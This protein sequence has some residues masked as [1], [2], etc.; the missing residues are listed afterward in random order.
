M[1]EQEGA[2]IGCGFF[3][4][5][6]LH[7]WQE[8]EGA[9]IEAVCDLEET[10][11]AQ[12]A[13]AFDI[14]HVY[15]DMNRMMAERSLDFVDVVTQMDS[16]GEIVCAVAEHELPVIC[17]KPLAGSLDEAR[18]IIETCQAAGIP[19]MVHEN[20]RWQRPMRK[21]AQHLPEIGDPFF[22]RISFRSGYD[23]YAD[24]PY[25]AERDRFILLDLGIHLLDLARFFFGE[26][27]RL[28]CETQQVNP[29]IEGEDV[30]TVLLRAETGATVI[31]DV[32]YASHVEEE[33][34]PQTFVRLEGPKGTVNLGPDFHLTHA[35][36]ETVN[37]DTVAPA[38]YSWS[39]EPAQ[40]IQDSV[41]A[42]QQHWVDCLQ[43]QTAPETSGLDNL[44]T[45]ALVFGA[46]ESA[47]RGH[48][49]DL[50]RGAFD[51]HER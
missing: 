50:R 32:S 8:V 36:N 49:V 13:E 43:A 20:F 9:H 48:P 29:E 31:V 44:N 16:H 18:S 10:R 40:A 37:K 11:A 38:T 7:G 33:Y 3:S 15:T 42:I 34:F 47:R 41:V 27:D 4:Q 22:G 35:Q 5:N 30:A 17:Q 1:A 14:D 51:V 39:R 46:Y 6:H 26:F 23:V 12:K 28:T 2:V 45:L 24:Q 19:T 21:V 25:L